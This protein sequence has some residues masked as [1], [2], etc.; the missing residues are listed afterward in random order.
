MKYNTL[1]LLSFGAPV[2]CSA[3]SLLPYAGECALLDQIAA[4]AVT[5]S[6][7]GMTALTLMEKVALGR[8]ADISPESE[9]QVGVAAGQLRQKGF[10]SAEAR[11]CAFHDIGRIGLPEAVDFLAKLRSA[12]MGADATGQVWPAQEGLANARLARITD[13]Q[14]RIEFLER[15]VRDRAPAA[16]WAVEQLC[17]GGDL[18]SRP[19]IQESIRSHLNGQ[20]N[21]DE[22]RFCE[23]RM[24]VVSRYP[25]RVKALGSV[26]SVENIMGRFRLS[27]G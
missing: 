12:D 19:I 16:H 7:T 21:E 10:S 6:D 18:A 26:L 2:L 11:V 23:A 22:I 14:L 15:M 5:Q 24:H 13:P 8:A 1:L 17:N 20:R 25:D 9:A 4:T 3:T 27:S